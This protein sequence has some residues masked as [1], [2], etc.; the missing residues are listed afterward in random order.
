[1]T[2]SRGAKYAKENGI[3]VIIFPRSDDEPNA[4]TTDEVLASLR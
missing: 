2:D 3:P 1:M 4:L